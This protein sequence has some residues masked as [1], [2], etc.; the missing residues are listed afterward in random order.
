MA[1]VDGL[2]DAIAEPLAALLRAVADWLD[3]EPEDEPANAEV[4]PQW[5]P[6]DRGGFDPAT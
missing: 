1:E 6:N 4:K 2:L 5:I 3:E